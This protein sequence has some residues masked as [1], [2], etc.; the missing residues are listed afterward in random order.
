MRRQNLCLAFAISSIGNLTKQQNKVHFRSPIDPKSQDLTKF[1]SGTLHISH[2]TIHSHI[3]YMNLEFY[4]ILRIIMIVFVKKII[5][6]VEQKSF[7][8]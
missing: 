3:T 4:K 8:L 7:V 5:L 1:K 6:K 2:H